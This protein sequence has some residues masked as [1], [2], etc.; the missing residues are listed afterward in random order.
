MAVE[1]LPQQDE[2]SSKA[3][4]VAQ[5]Q[6]WVIGLCVMVALI[7]ACYAFAMNAYWAGDDYNY[8]R[9]KDWSAVLNFFNPVGRAQFRPLTWNTWALDYALFGA[10]PLGWHLT[11]LL[12]HIWNAIIAAFLL[13]AIT[14]K[15]DLALLGATLFALQPAQPQT[16]TW[17]GG[18]ADASFA[19][20]WLP[21]LLLFVL[22]R[23]GAGK[24]KGRWLWLAAGLLGFVSMFGKEAAVTLPIMSLWID[25]LFGREWAR[26]PG[27]RDKGWWRDRATVLSVLGDHSLFI[28]A[29]AAYSGMRLLL[30]VFNQGSLMYGAHQFALLNRPLGVGTGYVMVAAGFWWEPAFVFGWELVQKL[31]VLL[32]ALVI[33]GLLIRWLGKIAVF[34]V[35]WFMI[36]LILTLQEVELRWFYLPALGVGMLIAAAWSR[37]A[38]T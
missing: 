37:I 9:P 7:V 14:G 27:R 2:A 15:T 31:A 4:A 25:L 36:T 8:V 30:V 34:A 22:W 10:D 19:M 26:W 32:A 17:L 5:R 35:G 20:A 23:K 1:Q 33:V 24:G 13:R 28:A 16:V 38:T 12:Q 6:R 18:Q 3:E 29:S 21:A 11:R